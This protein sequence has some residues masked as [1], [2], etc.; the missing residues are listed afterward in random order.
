MEIPGGAT[1]E[2]DV[3]LLSI[4]NIPLGYRKRKSRDGKE[5]AEEAVE[6]S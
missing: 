2:M 6:E 5:V 3:E 4:K 1:L